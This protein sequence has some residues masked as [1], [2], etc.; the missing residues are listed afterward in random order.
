MKFSVRRGFSPYSMLMKNNYFRKKRSEHLED[1]HDEHKDFSKL[2][3]Q[4]KY[5]ILSRLFFY[6]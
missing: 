2:L 3:S 6:L 4:A 1:S 5:K